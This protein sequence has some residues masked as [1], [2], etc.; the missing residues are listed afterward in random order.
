M[1]IKN[2]TI[3]GAGTL[4]SQISFQTAFKG[5]TVT[6]YDLSEASLQSCAAAHKAYGEHFINDRGEDASAVRAGLSRIRYTTNL[7]EALEDCDLTSESVPENPEIK[8]HLYEQ[9]AELAPEKTLFTTNTSTMLPSDFAQF[10]GRPERFCALHFANLIW[11]INIAEIMGHPG[12]SESTIQ[13]VTNF[14]VAIGMIPVPIHKEQSGYV[15]NSLLVPI[16]AAAQSL[17]TNGV[18]TPE[19]VDQVYCKFNAP[20]ER[21]PFQFMDLIGLKTVH[22]VF[23]HLGALMG[24]EQSIANAEYLKENFLDK[25]HLGL[26]THKGYYTYPQ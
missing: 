3:L 6:V 14:A 16:L 5:F 15:L 22:D 19:V 24:D 12:T 2:V 1:T 20:A 17:V 11:D 26:K 23:Q 21:G 4:G 9:L 10:T 18:T 25:G 8:Q 13:Q 7:Q